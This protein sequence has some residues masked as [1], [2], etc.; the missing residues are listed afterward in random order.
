MQ[1]DNADEFNLSSVKFPKRQLS[2]AQTELPPLYPRYYRT[3]G[4]TAHNTAELP[5][6]GKSQNLPKTCS[7]EFP[8]RSPTVLPPC[9]TTANKTTVLPFGKNSQ[10]L[11]TNPFATWTHQIYWAVRTACH[12]RWISAPFG[13]S[14]RLTRF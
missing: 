11:R 7:L 9:G 1:Q 13:R 2:R 10:R 5:L 12:S 14:E 6:I 8:Y 3:R 4:R